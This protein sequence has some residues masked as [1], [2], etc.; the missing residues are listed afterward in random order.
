M[1]IIKTVKKLL[2]K[3]IKLFFKGAKVYYKAKLKGIKLNKAVNG[4]DVEIAGIPVNDIVQVADTM[5]TLFRVVRSYHK[6]PEACEMNLTVTADEDEADLEFKDENGISWE[7]EVSRSDYEKIT[8][9]D[10]DFLKG[11]C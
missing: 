10:I 6:L 7:Y 11:D 1:K 4:P 8:H 9:E 2:K 5:K 3:T